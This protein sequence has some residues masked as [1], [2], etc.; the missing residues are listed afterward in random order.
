M[1]N[2]YLI[3]EYKNKRF[4][5][6]Y[7]D[8]IPVEFIFIE[9]SDYT[10]GSIYIGHVESIIK[11]LNAAFVDLGNGIKGYLPLK[12]PD[13][14]KAGTDITVQIEKEA[15]KSKEI[16]LTEDISIGGKFL[17][18]SKGRPGIG[19]SRKISSEEVRNRL[20]RAFEE[21]IEN[22]P[23]L[24][25]F[26]AGKE[27]G[28]VV[29]TAAAEADF[30]EI[31]TE[32]VSIV[33]VFRKTVDFAENRTCHS[34]LYKPLAEYLLRIRDSKSE[35]ERIVTDLPDIYDECR[36]VFD[37]S[38]EII[39]ALALYEDE[40]LPLI[41]LYSIEAVF[42]EALHKKVWMRSGGFLVIEP[43]EALTV[44][45]VNSGKNIKGKNKQKLIFETN[46]EAVYETARQ[47][48]LR[49]ISGIIIIDFIN[50]ADE[51]YKVEIISEI[52][53][54]LKKDSVQTRFID[55]TPL[56]LAEVTREKIHRPLWENLRI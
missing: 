54:V 7:E 5:A 27:H 2:K 14:V 15:I 34:C 50:M 19:I 13:S 29:R 33:D 55:F 40:M 22:D 47:L 32:L 38:K 52:K 26:F 17:A 23:D 11:N 20:K 49:N 39:D 9:N 6:I 10:V 18:I 12:T 48:R 43:T 28:M 42:E 31:K 25:K 44:I 16:R 24:N 56:G 45:D 4:C 51:N 35:I 36:S 41:K 37:D 46:K 8:D 53:R 3:S 21:F 1:K 30:E